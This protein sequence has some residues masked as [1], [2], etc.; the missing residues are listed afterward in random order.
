MSIGKEDINFSQVK[1]R[2]SNLDSYDVFGNKVL[3]RDKR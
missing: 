1:C 3:T 2:K